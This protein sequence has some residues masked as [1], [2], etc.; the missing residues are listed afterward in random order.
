[1]AWHGNYAPYKYDT[2]RFCPVNSVSFDH[3]DPSIFTV[4]TC[5]S[6]VPGGWVGAGMGRVFVGPFLGGL[7]VGVV[8]MGL[9]CAYGKGSTLACQD[10]PVLSFLAQLMGA[11]AAL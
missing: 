1:M 8:D 7:K 10:V 9:G 4:L 6:A 2:A 11:E 3:P 5:P